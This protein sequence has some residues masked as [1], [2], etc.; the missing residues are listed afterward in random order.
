MEMKNGRLWGANYKYRPANGPA[1]VIVSSGVC[2]FFFRRFNDFLISKAIKWYHLWGDSL[3]HV[4]RFSFNSLFTLPNK[5]RNNS[6]RYFRILLFIYGLQ[7]IHEV[8]EKKN[9]KEKKITIDRS[10]LIYGI[11]SNER[12][13]T[14]YSMFDMRAR[15]LEWRSPFYVRCRLPSI[16]RMCDR[17]LY[18][19]TMGAGSWTMANR[20]WQKLPHDITQ[21]LLLLLFEEIYSER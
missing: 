5:L 21:L 10:H 1:S 12:V 13:R 9:K 20:K 7:M 2:F 6:H 17:V 19:C 16:R 18:L 8:R 14:N 3:T 4:L 15:Y 11:W